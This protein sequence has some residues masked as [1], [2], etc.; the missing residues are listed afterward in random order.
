PIL[1]DL[2]IQATLQQFREEQPSGGENQQ[3]VGFSDE[4]VITGRHSGQGV[5]MPRSN[6]QTFMLRADIVKAVDKGE[7]HMW[8][9]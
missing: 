5:I 4:C 1:L 3:I 9:I 2:A 7:F 8:A 6:V